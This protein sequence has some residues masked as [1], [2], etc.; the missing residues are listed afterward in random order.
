MVC[1]IAICKFIFIYTPSNQV[2]CVLRITKRIRTNFLRNNLWILL[3]QIG[4]CGLHLLSLIISWNMIQ[5]FWIRRLKSLD[6]NL[7]RHA[8]VKSEILAVVKPSGDLSQV[9]SF[10]FVWKSSSWGKAFETTLVDTKVVYKGVNQLLCGLFFLIC[11]KVFGTCHEVTVPTCHH[12]LI[13]FSVVM[14]VAGFRG[15]VANKTLSWFF[16]LLLFKNSFEFMVLIVPCIWPSANELLI[17]IICDMEEICKRWFRPKRVDCVNSAL[18]AVCSSSCDGDVGLWGTGKTPLMFLLITI[19]FQS[20]NI[21]HHSLS[22][23]LLPCWFAFC[24]YVQLLQEY[25]Q[26][27]VFGRLTK[28]LIYIFFFWGRGEMGKESMGY[29]GM[30]SLIYIPL[31]KITYFRKGNLQI[32]LIKISCLF[33]GKCLSVK[34]KI[35]V[36][37][38]SYT[39]LLSLLFI[40]VCVHC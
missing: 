18:N 7:L 40:F 27:V 8:V 21:S 33:R 10:G 5:T 35:R 31:K 37:L 20:W 39:K 24:V 32:K 26:R 22:E 11:R 9:A 2:N 3:A 36:Y 23:N 25:I 30:H 4:K 1:Q 34:Y 15:I 19:T 12:N 38:S 16:F 6:F 28:C 29:L 14:L 17:V 13:F